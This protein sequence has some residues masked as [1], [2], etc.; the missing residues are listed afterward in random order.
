M[1][2]V[3]VDVVS[4]CVDIPQPPDDS[5]L[6]S[7]RV[8]DFVEADSRMSLNGVR[9]AIAFKGLLAQVEVH[10][11]EFGSA[12]HVIKL[13]AKSRRIYGHNFAFVSSVGLAVATLIAAAES[14]AKRGGEIVLAFFDFVV[15][16]VVMTYPH[17]PVIVVEDSMKE[18]DPPTHPG[19]L[20]TW[21]K[22]T[23]RDPMTVLTPSFPH[24]NSCKTMCLASVRIF[25]VEVA[26]AHELLKRAQQSNSRPSW[27]ELVAPTDA[28]LASAPALIV[29]T[30]TGDDAPSLERAAGFTESKIRFLWYS[31]E[32]VGLD[33]RLLPA[34]ILSERSSE[35]RAVRF[36]FV[37]RTQS[38]ASTAMLDAA[39][40]VAHEFR[41]F[42]KPAADSSP[43]LRVECQVA[44][45]ES[46][47]FNTVVAEA[48]ETLIHQ[49]VPRHSAP[50][51][52]PTPTR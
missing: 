20:D 47:L 43:P 7:R 40:R 34:R 4:V 50:K 41:F 9:T 39:D 35:S 13:W 42:L 5:L 38:G 18:T 22:T 36:V 51:C 17:V 48:S 11:K 24:V 52:P 16:K 30:A 45:N 37:V 29:V 33:G 2:A 25:S 6:G 27:E 31:A 10:E 23:P 26:R 44:A 49:R 32:A 15:S 1:N 28:G 21:S 46:P 12:L 8:F 19:L 3:H 14:G